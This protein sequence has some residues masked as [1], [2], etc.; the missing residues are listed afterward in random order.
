MMATLVCEHTYLAGMIVFKECAT[1][2]SMTLEWVP[3]LNKR[4]GS[5][6]E[7]API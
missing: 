4:A 1:D 7:K 3:V 6:T 2:P 5:T